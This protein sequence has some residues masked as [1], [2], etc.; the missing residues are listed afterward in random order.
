M[1]NLSIKQQAREN[2]HTQLGQALKK[3]RG[4]EV[5][6]CFGDINHNMGFRGFHLRGLRKQS[7]FLPLGRPRNLVPTQSTYRS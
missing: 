5:E 1:N 7:Q 4:I 3:R 6:S 2:L